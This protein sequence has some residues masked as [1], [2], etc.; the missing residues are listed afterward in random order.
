MKAEKLHAENGEKL[1]YA[2]EAGLGALSEANPEL[3]KLFLKFCA[4]GR[5]SVST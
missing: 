2:S 1:S 3:V 4:L 5:L